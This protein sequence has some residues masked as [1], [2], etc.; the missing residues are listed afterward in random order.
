[1]DLS[2]ME[3]SWQLPNEMRAACAVIYRILTWI[4]GLPICE[5]AKYF[6]YAALEELVT[7]K[8]KYGYDEA[9]DRVIEVKI[10][11]DGSVVRLELVDDGPEFDP[12]AH[13]SPDIARHLEEGAD[14]G[15]GLELVRR[16][17][18][19]MEYRRDGNLNRVSLC[20]D[21]NAF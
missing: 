1:M 16:I 20:L 11:I 6:T 8:I 13:P 3:G 2:G 12:T 19:R 17:C 14:G 4:D 21:A 9:G 7:N 5:D 10:A 18:S 15:L